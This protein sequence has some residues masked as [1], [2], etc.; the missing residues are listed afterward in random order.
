MSFDRDTDWRGRS[1]EVAK[2]RRT[3]RIV[4]LHAAQRDALSASR[5]TGD[6]HWDHLLT[7][8]DRKSVV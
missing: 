6:E 1:A 2:A 3:Q 8:L 5:V 7:I 4:D